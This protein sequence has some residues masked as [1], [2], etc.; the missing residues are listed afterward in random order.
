M[1]KIK[2]N[3]FESIEDM[4]NRTLSNT[5]QLSMHEDTLK[6]QNKKIEMLN[7]RL[8]DLFEEIAELKTKK[9]VSHIANYHFHIKESF[10]ITLFNKIKK[11]FKE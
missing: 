10:I 7:S 4:Q 6:H 9:P 1:S 2:K 3:T 5:C 8:G 11:L